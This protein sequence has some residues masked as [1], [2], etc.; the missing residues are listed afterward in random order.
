[1][2]WRLPW[3]AAVPCDTMKH[4]LRC[5]ALGVSLTLLF[6]GVA[7]AVAC[8]RP[9]QN[10]AKASTPAA[11]PVRTLPS[12]RPTADWWYGESVD[13]YGP[14]AW[15]VQFGADSAKIYE[16]PG[17]TRLCRDRG[18]PADSIRWRANLEPSGR[19][20]EIDG[21]VTGEG[22]ARLTVRTVH[23][24]HAAADTTRIT[25]HPLLSHEPR[26]APDGVYSTLSTHAETGDLLGKELL[27]AEASTG[28]VGALVMGEGA[29]S[30][31]YPMREITLVHDTIRF[32]TITEGGR[33]S[34]S[35]GSA[36][37]MPRCG[38]PVIL[39]ASGYPVAEGRS[40]FY[41]ASECAPARHWDRN[42]R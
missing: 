23:L 12:D 1:M 16:P 25:L 11:V 17:L 18:E 9:P 24:G 36:R 30:G 41:G 20:S 32:T 22:G 33:S 28:L 27:L 40:N 10:D 8:D 14:R 3:L 42:C 38:S 37:A 21:P 2:E 29:A 19:V 34:T 13:A 7:F 39:S 6:T 35:R 31:P 15:F 26:T 4:N 5:V